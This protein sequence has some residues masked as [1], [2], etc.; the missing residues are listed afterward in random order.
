M[1]KNNIALM[2]DKRSPNE[3]ILANKHITVQSDDSGKV[4]LIT[5]L[6]ADEILTAEDDDRNL[7]IVGKS[8]SKKVKSSKTLVKYKDLVISELNTASGKEYIITARRPPNGYLE[9]E[10]RGPVESQR[11]TSR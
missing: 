2:C 6:D 7:I 8:D 4:Y 1:P 11:R 5:A 10:R 3:T 9:Q